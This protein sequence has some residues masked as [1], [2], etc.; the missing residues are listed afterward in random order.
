MKSKDNLGGSDGLSRRTIVTAAAWAAPAIVATA[1]SPAAAA[2]S[3]GA[4]KLEFDAIPE[5]E[6]L[7]S[8]PAF[9]ISIYE[10]DLPTIADPH[11][12]I[13]TLPTG[14]EWGDPGSGVGG[15][16]TIASEG[17]K[18]VLGGTVNP[19][20]AT[21]PGDYPIIAQLES[22]PS[23]T[24]SAILHVTPAHVY[25]LDWA[26]PGWVSGFVGTAIDTAV[27]LTVTRDGVAGQ[28]IPVAIRPGDGLAWASGDQGERTVITEAN[29]L[30]T[31]AAGTF[32]ASKDGMLALTATAGGA[33]KVTR[34]LDVFTVPKDANKWVQ[35]AWVTDAGP[36]AVILAS[37]FDGPYRIVYRIDG[38]YLME[39]YNGSQFYSSVRRAGTNIVQTA[40]ARN[41]TGGETIEA[42]VATGGPGT[43][44]KAQVK[45]YSLRFVAPPAGTSDWVKAI[46]PAAPG[47]S[48]VLDRGAFDGPNRL[49]VRKNGTFVMESYKGGP[50]YASSFNDGAITTLTY[51]HESQGA[52]TFKSGDLVEVYL[53]PGTAGA[54]SAGRWC[55][56]TYICP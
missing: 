19:I 24:V 42:F 20:A 40:T 36:V 56:A 50:L 55:I 10:N 35:D 44:V 29:G 4:F 47:L 32:I 39:S 34:D 17:G 7:S 33:N 52:L 43:A 11:R 26:A 18:L 49:Q 21:N 48:V 38:E 25:T 30:I 15:A 41:L 22:D 28:G 45:I 46:T 51:A 9:S 27:T 53:A 5:A 8:V 31:F 23:V 12:L 13:I 6:A 14:L 16:R 2:S 3:K 1:T 54:K 37:A